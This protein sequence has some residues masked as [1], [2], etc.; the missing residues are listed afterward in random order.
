MSRGRELVKNTGILF[1]AKSLTQVVSF[2]L[3]PLYTAILSTSEYGQL[4]I[5]SSMIMI[6]LPF[7][8]LQLE[9]AIFR[10]VIAAKSKDEIEDIITTSLC[11]I[12]ISSSI[13]SAIYIVLNFII[14]LQYASILYFYYFSSIILTVLLQVCRGFS[15]NVTFSV[16]S[17]ISAALAV[18]LNVVFVAVLRTGISGVIYSTIIA[19]IV[20][21]IYMIYEVQLFR[22][23]GSTHFKINVIKEM[24]VYSGPLI[25]NQTSSWII[26]Y[27]DRLIVLA[28]LGIGTNGIYSLAS[29]FSNLLIT[30]FGVYNIAWTENVVRCMDDEDYQPYLNNVVTM[31]CQIYLCIVTGIINL[32]PL[33]F[34]YFINMNYN[35]AYQH[36]PIL[37]V[38]MFFSG[39]AATLGSIYVAHKKTKSVGLTTCFAGAINAIVLLALINF[40]GLYAAS[41]STLLSFMALFLYRYFDMKKFENIKLDYKKIIVPTFILLVSW[42]AYSVNN[43]LYILIGLLINCSYL[44]LFLKENLKGIKKLASKNK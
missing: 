30:I 23:L 20:S 35:D 14:H 4:D 6:F 40:I 7:V 5:Y 36:I 13:F 17:F 3:L 2:L 10:F 44:L 37:L 43:I 18:M 24:L 19:N 12:L 11:T 22:Y 42:I 39:M 38:G 27:S 15:K 8:T 29:K 28:F 1:V 16:A 33:V 31:T 32:L 9:Q 34:K 21:S 26:N 41:I 25:L